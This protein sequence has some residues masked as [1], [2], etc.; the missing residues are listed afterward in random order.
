[1]SRWWR[2]LLAVP[3]PLYEWAAGKLLVRS[4]KAR[5]RRANGLDDSHEIRHLFAA[6]LAGNS[7]PC[8]GGRN[9]HLDDALMGRLRLAS[10][11][12][13]DPM[14]GVQPPDPRPV[15]TAG[16]LRAAQEVAER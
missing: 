11:P 13:E 14:D 15:Q 1:M 8:D 2:R 6:V 3:V 9:C 10:F 5:A 16:E 7:D 4:A 12:V